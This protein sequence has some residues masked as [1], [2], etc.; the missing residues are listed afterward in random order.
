MLAVDGVTDASVNLA[1]ESA[2]VSF[3]ESNALS[4]VIAALSDAGYPARTQSVVLDVQGM[5]CASC[6]GRIEKTLLNIDGVT[7]A[8]AN[9]ATGTADVR[10][11]G[12]TLNTSAIAGIL[13]DAGYASSVRDEQSGQNSDHRADQIAQLKR[14]TL[15]A[16]AFAIPVF[17]IEMGSH[18]FPAFREL[19]TTTLGATNSHYVQFLLTSVV[20]FGPG[21][22]FYRTGF[23]A[24]IRGAPTMN[25]LVALGTSAAY[26]FSVVSTFTPNLLPD[27]TANVYYEAAAVIVVLILFG[28]YLE[29]RAKGRTGSAIQKLIGLQAKTGRVERDDVIVDLE[30][31]Q[32]VQG[33]K[34]HVRP[35]E[36][37]PVDGIV[38]AGQSFVDESMITGEPIPVEKQT[39]AHVSG[40][41][42]NGTGSL[43]Y[44]AT[45]VGKDTLLAQ[46][47]TMVEQAQGA[48]LPIQGLVDQISAWFVPVVILIA[49]ITMAVWFA[50]GPEPSL[51]YALVAG[52][53]VLIIACPCAMGLATPTSIMVGTG[54]AASKGVLFRQGDALQRLQ[55]VDTIA[56]D[57]TGT[58]TQGAPELTHFE[59]TNGFSEEDVLVLIASVEALSEHPISDAIVRAAT[60]RDLPTREPEN[61]L[62]HTGYGVQALVDGRDVLIGADRLMSRENIPMGQ[63]LEK[64]E[65]LAEQGITPLYA[66]IDGQLAAVIG[67]T[68]PIK[69]GAVTAVRTLQKMGLTP[70]MITGD[71]ALTARNIADELG[72]D[73]VIAGVLP[74]GK[75]NT[76]Q[77]LQT[78]GQHVAFVGDGINDAPALAT[79]DVGIAIGTG[80]DVAIEAADVVLMSGDLKGVVSAI[81]VSQQTIRNIKQNLFWAFAY[82]ILLIPIAAGVLYPFYGIVL[83]PMLAA[84]AMSLSSIFVLANALRLRWI[85]TRVEST[86]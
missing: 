32:I 28:R 51:S 34:I 78:N 66:A 48:K 13:T 86:P 37:F 67:V 81:N 22:Q 17:I 20:L 21:L 7:S 12:T 42:I 5:S 65:A 29:A 83:S 59:L 1:Q 39:D 70:V 79:A 10:F 68:D 76:V 2:T 47:V 82:N 38:L 80:T 52:V 54:T 24:L 58:L 6:V 64:G 71:N 45:A 69:E 16:A 18:L 77:D 25:S 46:I 19:I 26:A 75:V 31:D 60:A 62:S 9:L 50:V 30:I 73:R 63:L 4:P 43:T 57:K 40:G 11:T 55:G 74:G 44:R 85:N 72:I 49:F 15:I 56:F 61:F 84:A 35:G 41:T 23:P 33:D 36:K 14:S 27:G 53:A 3:V 8:S